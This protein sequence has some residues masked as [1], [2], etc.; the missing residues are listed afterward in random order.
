MT[1]ATLPLVPDLLCFSHLRWDFVFQ[2]PQHL[3]T[4]FA[5]ER[6]V[7]FFEEAV[8]DAAKPELELREAEAG[9]LRAIPHLP[10]GIAP[11]PALRALVDELIADEQIRR[12]V[13]WYYTPMALPF[14]RHLSPLALAYDCMDELSLFRGAPP[15]LVE[16]ENELLKQADVVFTGGQSL[17][18]AKRGRH[19]NVHAFPSSVDVQHFQKARASQPDPIDQ[20]AIGHPRLGF[21]GVLDERLDLALLRGLAEARPQWQ[22]ILVGP[23]VKIDP[24]LLPRAPNIHYLGMKK[25]Q[26]LPSY[27]AGW[28]VALLL[29]ARNE[30]TRFISP[31]K[32]PEYL[33]AGKPVVS[34]SIRDV[35]SPYGARGF[36]EIADTPGE[37]VS[38][39]EACLRPDAERRRR[40]DAFLTRMSWDET[41]ARMKAQLDRCAQRGQ[42]ARIAAA[43]A[44]EAS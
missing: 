18:E 17:Y 10:P 4:R 39:V 41:F 13:S 36:V 1:D 14:S 35:V 9:V 12:Y 30:A 44:A 26:E 38:A 40:A 25:Y 22:L 33:A 11:D 42:K 20:A 2:R 27:L 19:G 29:F 15:A 6:R 16:L 7:F 28:D 34:T 23:V 3:L 32:T 8:H 43:R 5:S 24:A 21:F 37:F 31:T